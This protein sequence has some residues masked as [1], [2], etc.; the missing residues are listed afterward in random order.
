M[1]KGLRI[2][3]LVLLGVT[4][5]AI[6][7]LFIFQENKIEKE[8]I[9]KEVELKNAAKA[10]A[11]LEYKNDIIKL[12]SDLLTSGKTKDTIKVPVVVRIPVHQY[13]TI[14]HVIFDGFNRKLYEL[15]SYGTRGDFEGIN[16]ESKYIPVD[17]DSSQARYIKKICVDFKTKKR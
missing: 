12:Y 4:V 5:I 3:K 17:L 8:K 6:P 13:D 1:D 11:Q 7:I 15:V 14:R 16:V 10:E 2:L 9:D